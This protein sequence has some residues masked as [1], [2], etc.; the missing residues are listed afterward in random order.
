MKKLGRE[1]KWLGHCYGATQWMSRHSPMETSNSLL[2]A[3]SFL[4]PLLFLG[5]RKSAIPVADHKRE[6]DKLIYDVFSVNR[7]VCSHR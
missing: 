6:E 1:I 3:K 7:T 2:Y 4:S 5:Y